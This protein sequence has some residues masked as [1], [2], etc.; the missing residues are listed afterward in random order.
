MTSGRRRRQ[1]GLPVVVAWSNTANWSDGLFEL[2]TRRH[3]VVRSW[4]K[5]F[6]SPAWGPSGRRIAF[7]K[8][9]FVNGRFVSDIFVIRRDGTHLER[10]TYTRQK[11]EWDLDW[12]SRNL[13]VFQRG[14]RSRGR[15]LFTIRPT[16]TR[17][18]P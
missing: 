11:P 17:F 18:G 2:I 1:T 6:Y 12:S 4:R 7:I 10:V 8:G 9:G 13:L 16:A 15:E 5:S 3:L 14:R